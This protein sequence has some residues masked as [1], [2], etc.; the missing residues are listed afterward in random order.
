MGGVSLSFYDWYSD[1]PPASPE[2]WGEQTDVQE[3][4]DWYNA[5]LLAVVGSESEHDPHARLP[6]RGRGSSQRVEDVGLL[7]GL[8]ARSRSTPTS[9]S[10]SMRDRTAPG[11]WR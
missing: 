6:L 3:S 2:T 8:L 11:G 9:G 10:R 7:A 4:A 5:K 1:L